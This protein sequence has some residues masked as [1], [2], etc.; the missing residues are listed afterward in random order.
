MRTRAAAP[1]TIALNRDPLIGISSPYGRRGVLSDA[2]RKH[3]GWDGDVLVWQAPTC[4]GRPCC[5]VVVGCPRSLACGPIR[6]RGRSTSS[7]ELGWIPWPAPG[8]TVSARA[9]MLRACAVDP[10][11]S[12]AVLRQGFPVG[13]R[14]IGPARDALWFLLTVRRQASVFPSL[15]ITPCVALQEA[16]T[17]ALVWPGFRWHDICHKGSSVAGVRDSGANTPQTRALWGI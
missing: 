1:W 15:L 13:G 17:R 12:R 2:Y 3:H 9:R 7:T 14:G 5:H 8:W 11:I 4:P 10:L 6:H 16:K